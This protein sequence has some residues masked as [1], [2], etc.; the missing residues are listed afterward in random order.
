MF[1]WSFVGIGKDRSWKVS[2]VVDTYNNQ[3]KFQ[4]RILY[5]QNIALI[6][7]WN[8]VKILQILCSYLDLYSIRN[9]SK[10]FEQQY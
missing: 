8:S 2:I 6:L 9:Q 4:E 3:K 10:H 1:K 7:H 5:L